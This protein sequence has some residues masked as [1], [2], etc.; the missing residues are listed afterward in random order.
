MI[1]EDIVY[2]FDKINKHFGL[3][4]WESNKSFRGKCPIHDGDNKSSVSIY[5]D[6]HTSPG[7]WKCFT[8]NCHEK[9]GGSVIGFIAGLLSKRNNR[10]YTR[11]EAIAWCEQFF[12]S[13]YKQPEINEDSKL[14]TFFNRINKPTPQ[15]AF[16][17]SVQDFKSKLKEP[18][19]FINRDYKEETLEHFKVGYCDNKNK[20]F[21]DRVVVPQ[22]DEEGYVIA[23]LGRSVHESC[24][25]C[26]HYHN[27]KGICRTFPK[28]RN[29]DS[30][31]S[32]NALYNFYSAKKSIDDTGI[33][34]VT[35]SSANTWRL[36]EAGFT[37]SI[38]S[39]GSK[40]SDAQ[41]MLLDTSLAQTIIVVPDA[42]E[43]GKILI[44]QIEEH[45][46]FTHNIITISPS[47]EDDIG[48]CN[49]ETVKKIIGPY[50]ER[51]LG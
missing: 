1:L 32:Y 31:P 47:Y 8:G 20:P 16:R 46:K 29:S 13:K 15:Y 17:I 3:E 2:N 36:F 43:P 19:Y 26:K 21:Y 5:K 24:Q 6:G 10:E 37:M 23:C 41:K 27:P 33:V 50:V 34:I 18:T 40:F 42:G 48:K 4:L 22:F 35:E 14:T 30:F 39:F 25:I 38:G 45:C 49:V 9:Y 44:N 12:G 51:Q 7:N 28:W 11:Q